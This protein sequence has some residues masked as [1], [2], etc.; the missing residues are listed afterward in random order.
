MPYRSLVLNDPPQFFPQ[1]VGACYHYSPVSVGLLFTVVD[2]SNTYGW[3]MPYLRND[4]PYGGSFVSGDGITY[5]EYD[6]STKEWFEQ[7]RDYIEVKAQPRAS[8]GMPKSGVLLF[9]RRIENPISTYMARH[10]LNSSDSITKLD[11]GHYITYLKDVWIPRCPYLFPALRIAELTVRDIYAARASYDYMSI[12]SVPHSAFK[13]AFE[14]HGHMHHRG[15]YRD[16]ST[17]YE[18]DDGIIKSRQNQYRQYPTVLAGTNRRERADVILQLFSPE[19]MFNGRRQDGIRSNDRI[20]NLLPAATKV[21]YY[22]PFHEALVEE[23][24]KHAKGTMDRSKLLPK[25]AWY[26][27]GWRY[28]LDKFQFNIEGE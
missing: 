15:K 26:M 19:L 13:L 18:D 6:E 7:P 23:S 3:R 10:G 16:N 11:P 4:S 9:L 2:V 14:E 24:R 5:C 1:A 27:R 28:G 8:R 25:S 12:Q 21:R 22:S 17:F 20:E